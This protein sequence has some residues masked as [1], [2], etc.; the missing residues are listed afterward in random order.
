MLGMKALS[1]N[2]IRIHEKLFVSTPAT[3]YL[4]KEC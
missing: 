2:G 4:A 3:K 1:K